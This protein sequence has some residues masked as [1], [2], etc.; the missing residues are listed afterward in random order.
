M[1]RFLE[2]PIFLSFSKSSCIGYW[3]VYDVI[4]YKRF[5]KI[6]NFLWQ[7]SIIF[8]YWTLYMHWTQIHTNIGI[9]VVGKQKG[10]E[11]VPADTLSKKTVNNLNCCSNWF[12]DKILKISVKVQ[13]H[14][15]MTLSISKCFK[16]KQ[17]N[18]KIT[19]HEM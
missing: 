19:R 8:H 6:F 12:G 11:A 13:S 16:E 2:G 17:N 4:I 15:K 18:S 7:F 3:L 9:K 5:Y 10:K 14:Y 1:N